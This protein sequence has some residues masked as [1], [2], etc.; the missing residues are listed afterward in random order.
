MRFQIRIEN[1]NQVLSCS[2]DQT[3]LRCTEVGFKRSI[4][5][6][7]RQGGCGVCKVQVLEGSYRAR[8][9]S[10]AHI[11]RDDEDH[12][13]VLACCIWPTSDL[14]IAVLGRMKRIQFRV[15]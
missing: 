12:G 9:M 10:R 8:A 2:E 11:T 1:S 5:V 14:R 13:R 3:V 7:C 15:L 6:G 4:P